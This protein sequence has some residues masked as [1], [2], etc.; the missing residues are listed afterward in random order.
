MRT[1]TARKWNAKAK[2]YSDMSSSKTADAYEYDINFPSIMNLMPIKPGTI[3]DLG[4]GDGEF[5][6][7]FANKYKNV[8]G[9]DASPEMIKIASSKFPNIQFQVLD[10]E[11][12]FNLKGNSVDTIVMK[13]VLMFVENLENVAEQSNRVTHKAGNLIISVHH[14]MY[15]TAN[16]LQDKYGDKER[17]A[18]RVLK[19]G[20][21]TEKPIAKKIANNKSLEFDFIH[22]T[23]QTYIN[24]FSKHDF[25]LTKV[26]EPII[27]SNFTKKHPEFKN[28]TDIPMRLNMLFKKC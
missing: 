2:E 11:N 6:N 14:P 28:R 1:Q 7:L 19:N 15:W 18:F 13:L 23:F 4:C 22:R 12:R 21:F 27:P 20:Y 24:T 3:L 16:Y 10:L 5:T 25:V 17:R 8:I 9:A 26:D